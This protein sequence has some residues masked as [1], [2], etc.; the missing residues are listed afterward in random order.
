[1]LVISGGLLAAIGL[2]LGWTQRSTDQVTLIENP[3]SPTQTAE[4][5]KH[6]IVDVAGAVETPGVYAL[7]EEARVEDALVK[8]GGFTAEADTAYITKFINRAQVLS[9]G[10]KVYIPERG[11]MESP[12]SQATQESPATGQVVGLISNNSG[13]INVNSASQA[14]LETMWGIGAARAESIIANRPFATLEELKTKA[15]IPQNVLDR[16]ADVIAF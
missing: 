6:I 16:N 15:S 3:I 8:A 7:P 11:E 12:Q 4:N 2:V 10:A 13:S 14:E 5:S 9:D 1:M